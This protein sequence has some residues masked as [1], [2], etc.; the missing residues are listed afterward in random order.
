MPLLA[1]LSGDVSIRWDLG[2]GETIS[3]AR[4][5]AT[6]T[7]EPVTQWPSRFLH[8]SSAEPPFS[9]RNLMTCD[10]G[11]RR[12]Q[13]ALLPGA[14]DS[15]D[16]RVEGRDVMIRKSTAA[17]RRISATLRNFW[18]DLL[19]FLGFVVDVNVRFTGLSIH[20]WLGIVLGGVLVYHVL[21]HWEWIVAVVRRTFGRL[22]AIHRLKALVDLLLF[23]DMVALIATGLWISEAALPAIGLSFPRD[24]AWRLIHRLTADAAIWLLGAHLALNW[25]WIVSA[26]R[27]YAL[28]VVTAPGRRLARGTFVAPGRS[29]SSRGGA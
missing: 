19:L 8:I 25:P 14:N 9:P 17:Q 18:L 21:V 13:C 2:Q 10:V 23:L 12:R 5:P 20:E 4:R 15:Q 11:L 7:P 26:F 16:E 27:R 29:S 3:I 24:P 6:S 28:V 22:P 1:R